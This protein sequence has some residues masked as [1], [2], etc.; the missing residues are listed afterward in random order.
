MSVIPV[1]GGEKVEED[2]NLRPASPVK[3]LLRFNLNKTS[4]VWWHMPETWEA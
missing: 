1:T 3:M 2:H 4:Q